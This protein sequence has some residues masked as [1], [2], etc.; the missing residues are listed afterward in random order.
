MSEVRIAI[1]TARLLLRLLPFGLIYRLLGRYARSG[2]VLR[3]V[4]PVG[5]ALARAVTESGPHATCLV[6]AF[7]GQFLLRRKGWA[8]QIAIGARGEGGA[9]EAHAW[10]R[11]AGGSIL[12]GHL[13]SGYQE[14][15]P[16]HADSTNFLY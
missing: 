4:D 10:L 16:L 13:A 6:Q 14:L 3:T 9:L 5:N 12:G 8:S 1:G 2:R 11:C 15:K 7:A